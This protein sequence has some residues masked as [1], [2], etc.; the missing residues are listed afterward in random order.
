MTSSEVDYNS[1][2]AETEQKVRQGE[3]KIERL[4]SELLSA[5]VTL[6]ER[7]TSIQEHKQ[8]N[9]DLQH[10]LDELQNGLANMRY[11]SLDVSEVRA[12]NRKKKLRI[13]SKK[14]LKSLKSFNFLQ[15]I[16]E[17]KR[18]IHAQKQKI[19]DH[20]CSVQDLEEKLAA[21]TRAHDKGCQTIHLLLIKTSELAA[22]IEQLKSKV[23]T[24]SPLADTAAAEINSLKAKLIQ[25]QSDAEQANNWRK[26]CVELC[27]VLSIRLKE[28]AG[29]L[30][31]LLNHKNVL[32]VLAQD[33]YKAMR[34]AVDRSL[35]LSRSL[36]NMSISADPAGRFSMNEN[37][38]L[39]MS[40]LTEI[41][42]YSFS[43]T[44]IKGRS[45]TDAAVA[46]ATTN[47]SLIE[48][49][50]AEVQTL[51][52]K[53]ERVNAETLCSVR[54]DR[55]SRNLSHQFDL[56]SESEAWSEPD[57]KVSHERIGL[58]ESIKMSTHVRSPSSKFK[59]PSSSGSDD[60]NDSR[61]GR[62]NTVLRLQEKVLD[63]EN[64]LSA[65]NSQLALLETKLS[66]DAEAKHEQINSELDKSRDRIAEL[67]TELVETKGLYAAMEQSFD[68]KLSECNE[69]LKRNESERRELMD[70]LQELEKEMSAMT[71]THT[72]EMDALTNKHTVTLQL[73]HQQHIKDL[74]DVVKRLK[75]ETERDCVPRVT[76]QEKM[77]ECHEL[78]ERLNDMEKLAQLMRDNEVEM[79]AQIVEKEKTLRTIKRNADDVTMQMS[80]ALLERTRFLNERYEFEQAN[81]EFREKCDRLALEKSELL[82]KLASL[83]HN[84]AQLHNKLVVNETQ[85]QLTRSASQGN[86]RYALATSPKS[87]SCMAALSSG[88]DHSGYTSDEVKQRL[89][90]SSPDLGIESDGTGRSS[91][92][93]INTAHS[94][95][96][97]LRSSH[98]VLNAS[99]SNILLEGDED[100]IPD[101]P[102][103]S[104]GHTLLNTTSIPIVR[105]DCEMIEKEN[106]ALRRK[107][108]RVRSAF[109]K[110]WA[111]LRISN[112]R[113]EQIEK[114]IRQEIYKT[115]SVL[116]NVR[117]NI[118]S[119]NEVAEKMQIH[120]TKDDD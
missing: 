109:E 41:L 45:S 120:I 20:Q 96:S 101:I 52:Y 90:N 63:L 54:R 78:G 108:E 102:K 58:D 93:D 13:G 56:N 118:E 38:L 25:A 23:T 46:A 64:Q 51:Q 48:A 106:A 55:S 91:G 97:K 17:L 49:L 104:N 70:R 62:K 112:Q 65:K 95:I 47:T 37:A 79:K 86:A 98:T 29:F 69:N 9:E 80:K 59:V 94:P 7:S 116:K 42:N 117:T 1:K 15:D 82:S 103:T 74:D 34:N 61:S 33:R 43:D 16:C 83:A 4:T 27:G 89:E 67:Q 71:E 12:E 85:F 35:D 5:Q 66:S 114:D 3:Q 31:S 14:C 30:D 32:F 2:I 110:T 68:S 84:N 11:P 60:N 107:L 75:E 88:V 87:T 26:E 22:E 100:E 81:Q 99:F 18:Q 28:L 6:K 53:L 115:H 92:T 8:R 24:A 57:R 113:K 105:H 39:Q 44:L 40:S 119:V 19:A 111:C 50:R 10:Q 36:N 73:L 76:Y 21:K 77:H 72:R